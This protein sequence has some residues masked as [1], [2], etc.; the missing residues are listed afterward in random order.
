[1]N[2]SYDFAN[3][4]NTFSDI[5]IIGAGDHIGVLP[6]DVQEYLNSINILFEVQQTVRTLLPSCCTGVRLVLI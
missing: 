2:N 3:I 5:V 1:L 6:R 4:T